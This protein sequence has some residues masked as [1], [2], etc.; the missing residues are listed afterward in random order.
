MS[1]S[2]VKRGLAWTTT[3]TPP[4]ATKSTPARTSA[5]SSDVG[6]KSG[7]LATVHRAGL[8]E[9]AS[10]LVYRFQAAQSLCWCQFELLTDQAFIDGGSSRSC[11]NYQLNTGCSQRTIQCGE[12][13]VRVGSLELRHGCLADREPPCELSLRQSCA[14]S[15]IREQ[16]AR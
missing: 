2:R 10:L 12:A 4:M 15:R 6:R 1:R 16:L 13:R 8:R 11:R 5:P 14:P 9:L 7:Q 3:A